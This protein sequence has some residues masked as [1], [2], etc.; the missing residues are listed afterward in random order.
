MASYHPKY[1][2]E[3]QYLNFPLALP[4]LR[5]PKTV[6]MPAVQL[7]KLKKQSNPNASDT[8]EM[9]AVK[10]MPCKDSR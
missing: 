1:V 4:R 6:E 7:E 2:E 9:P 10:E 5:L 3:M 8:V